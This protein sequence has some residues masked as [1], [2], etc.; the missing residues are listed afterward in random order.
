MK[1]DNKRY[2]KCVWCFPLL[3]YAVDANAWGLYTHLFF[4]QWL[5]L[6]TPMLDPKV[7]AAIKKFPKLVLAG[8]CLPDLA[9][10]SKHFD[11]THCW[12]KAER[13]LKHATTEQEIAIAIGYH[14]HLFVDVIAHNH[15]VPAHEAS[16]QNASVIT[17]IASE[18][19]MDAHIA[20][21]V[22]HCPHHLILSNIENLSEFIAPHFDVSP[23][24]AK[25]KLRLLAWLDGLLRVTQLSSLILQFLKLNDAEFMQH[26][27]YYV[28]K[29][30]HALDDFHHTLKGVRPSWQPELKHLSTKELIDW[31]AQCLGDLRL[32]LA[33]PVDYY[34]R[35]QYLNAKQAARTS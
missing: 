23:R 21:Q 8:A 7:Q 15:F 17:H 14:S 29:T 20:Q 6:A 1:K 9:V 16:W 11:S 18:W 3:I 35:D 19:A 12:D 34:R 5:M 32:Q 27:N 24:L 10:I 28:A 25:R 31:R 4:S 33:T 13:M 22:R 30:S 2:L 26:L